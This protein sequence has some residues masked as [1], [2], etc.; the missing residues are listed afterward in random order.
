MQKLNTVYTD[1]LTEENAERVREVQ[2]LTL[3]QLRKRCHLNDVC[4]P[5]IQKYPNIGTAVGWCTMIGAPSHVSK[6]GLVALAALPNHY[7]LYARLSGLEVN[8]VACQIATLS[9]AL[10]VLLAI[11]PIADP[12]LNARGELDPYRDYDAAR[13]QMV[14][15]CEAIIYDLPAFKPALKIKAKAKAPR[16]AE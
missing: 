6:V 3:S 9:K 7:T 2:T 14:G 5:T 11:A 10:R 13:R 1:A 4:A 15:V 16:H 8:A 12:I